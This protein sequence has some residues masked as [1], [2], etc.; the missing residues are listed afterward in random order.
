MSERPLNLGGCRPLDGSG[1]THPIEIP[2]HHFTTHG[3][4]VGMTGSGKSGLLMVVVEEAL[5][6]KVPVLMIDVKATCRTF[7]SRSRPQRRGVRA[8][9]RSDGRRAGGADGRG[10]G[11]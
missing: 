5:R 8:V 2:P 1:D 11:L 7:F 9:D 3:I 6:S 10:G 4:A